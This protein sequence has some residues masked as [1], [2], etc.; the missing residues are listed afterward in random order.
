MRKRICNKAEECLM[1]AK[2]EGRSNVPCFIPGGTLVGL[3][4]RATHGA[5]H[6]PGAFCLRECRN[7][8]EFTGAYCVPIDEGGSHEG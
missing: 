4:E 5:S 7:G 8:S 2:I 1:L 6:T 3:D